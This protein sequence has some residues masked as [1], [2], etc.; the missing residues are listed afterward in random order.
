MI[1][2]R[3]ICGMSYGLKYATPKATFFGQYV[4]FQEQLTLGAMIPGNN[5]ITFST[6]L[7]YS[8][9]SG[10]TDLMVGM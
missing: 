4:N 5:Y 8:T 1:K 3:K 6:Q 10:D 9:M 7:D 2:P